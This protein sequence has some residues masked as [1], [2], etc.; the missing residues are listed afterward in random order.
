MLLEMKKESHSKY[1]SQVG[2]LGGLAR[3]EKFGNPG[4]A[5]GRSKGGKSAIEIH[6]KN[7]HT[8]FK[9]AKK[10]V[11]IRKSAALAEFMG[12]LFGDGHVGKYQ[13]TITLD[14]ETDAAY[15]SYVAKFIEEHF[16]V[17]PHIR[18]RKHARAVELCISSVEFSSMMVRFGM[19]EGN[20]I[21][22]NFR[23]PEWVFLSEVYIASFLRGLFDTDGSLYME[24]KIIKRRSYAYLG[25]IITSASPVLRTD[26]MQA[27]QQLGY[28]P[29]CTTR[30]FSVFLRKKKDIVSYFNKISSHNSKHRVRYEMFQTEAW[31]SGRMRMTRNHECG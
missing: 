14:S 21:H 30:Q 20:K 16:N 4:T 27:F 2:A 6:R 12:I 19:V 1:H 9:L 3:Y 11:P 28:A 7:T 10:I 5:E 26:I 29:T 25:M 22:G 15:A 13:T 31:Q 23:I 24:R 8:R 18:K 17:V